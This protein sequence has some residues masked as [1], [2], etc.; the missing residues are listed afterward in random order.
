MQPESPWRAEPQP[1]PTLVCD[2][3]LARSFCGAPRHRCSTWASSALAGPSEPWDPPLHHGQAGTQGPEKFRNHTEWH[4]L[5][6]EQCP[7]SRSV[8]HKTAA[9]LN[10]KRS[11]DPLN[12]RAALGDC[13]RSLIGGPDL[14]GAVVR[15]RGQRVA[16]VRSHV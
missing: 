7:S 13:L 6:A 9:S 3:P 14:D 1:I 4:M 12:H 5:G 16:A 8:R 15:G 2:A 11:G 10:S